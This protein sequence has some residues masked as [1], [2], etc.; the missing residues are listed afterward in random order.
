MQAVAA[1]VHVADL[2]GLIQARQNAL[3]LVRQRRGQLAAVDP[4]KQQLEALVAEAL[5][6]PG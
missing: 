3:D 6:S 2:G 4:L 1:Q 5:R